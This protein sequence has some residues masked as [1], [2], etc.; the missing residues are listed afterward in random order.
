MVKVVRQSPPKRLVLR[1]TPTGIKLIPNWFS[2]RPPLVTAA[3]DSSRTSLDSD[4]VSKTLSFSSVDASFRSF[5]S[6]FLTCLLNVFPLDLFGRF[7]FPSENGWNAWW[8]YC[9]C[10]SFLVRLLA[11]C[12]I[13]SKRCQ[14]SQYYFSL[15]RRKAVRVNTF[16]SAVMRKNLVIPFPRRTPKP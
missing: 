11:L 8:N 5:L 16:K 1:S 4:L 10:C 7:R 12:C 14:S 6:I 3:L 2:S 13:L 15:I 9:Y